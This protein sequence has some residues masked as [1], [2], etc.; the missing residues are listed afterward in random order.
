MYKLNPSHIVKFTQPVRNLP[1]FKPAI[2]QERGH[3]IYDFQVEACEFYQQILPN[4]FGQTKIW[5]FGG[6]CVGGPREGQRYCRSMP[7]PSFVVQRNIQARIRWVNH[8]RGQYM[9]PVD[10]S[11]QWA[12]PKGLG[13]ETG[14]R[15]YPY[16]Y[17]KMQAPVPMV[18]HM[19]GAQVPPIY[20]GHPDAW[21]TANNLRGPAF[22]GNT[23]R[24]LNSQEP[25]TLWYHDN[26]RGVSRLN[27]YS[28]LCGTYIIKDYAQDFLHGFEDFTLVIQDK[29]F[30][31]DGSLY[32]PVEANE[33]T[34]HPYWVP[35]FYGDVILVNGVSW[36]YMEVEKSAYRFRIVNASNTRSYELSLSDGGSFIQIATDGG[37]VEWPR[38]LNNLKLSPGERAEILMYFG[39]YHEGERLTLMNMAPD[40][41]TGTT[42]TIM[43]FRIHK[44]VKE[45][46]IR[47]PVRMNTIKQ[48][49]QDTSGRLSTINTDMEPD[50]N[51]LAFY[52][53]GQE[54][55]NPASYLN[56][57]GSTIIWDLLNLGD[58]ADVLHMSLIQ[59]QIVGRQS[60]DK[61]SYLEVW[62]EINGLLPLERPTIYLDPTSFALEEPEE[63]KEYE[64]G[65]KDTVSLPSGY[66][67]R[68][69]IRYAPTTAEGVMP[70]KNT[71]PFNPTIGGEYMVSS[72]IPERRDNEVL[73]PQYIIF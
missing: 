32:Y 43:Q 24:N 7:G 12:N 35:E 71:F 17:F 62:S 8:I 44:S 18:I 14:F 58:K 9:F 64:K 21:F 66:V 50:G 51:V 13:T 54:Q 27:L 72:A 48:L 2:L 39:G 31:E 23:V 3:L 56:R 38:M 45:E 60:I 53:D 28:G 16:G 41:D 15:P 57:V 46:S 5:G 73:R 36:P 1:V 26:T 65:W 4:D 33:D 67:T 29:S 61:K 20:D 22:T 47:L 69:M 42:D 49:T 63:A 70:G 59:F 19:H 11:L 6:N 40:S 34:I 25:A 30:Y 55:D 52:L 68:I 10:P 37:Y